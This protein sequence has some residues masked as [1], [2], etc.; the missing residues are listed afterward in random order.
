[1]DVN[2]LI[3]AVSSEANEEYEPD[4]THSHAASR[5]WT[6]GGCASG[7]LAS[8]SLTPARYAQA[9][10]AYT[11]YGRVH[12]WDDV[13]VLLHIEVPPADGGGALSTVFC[14]YVVS[15]RTLIGAWQQA[16]ASTHAAPLEDTFII[17]KVDRPH[18]AAPGAGVRLQRTRVHRRHV[19]EHEREHLHGCASSQCACTTSCCTKFITKHP[20]LLMTLFVGDFMSRAATHTTS[21]RTHFYDQTIFEQTEPKIYFSSRS[22]LECAVHL[23][24]RA[25]GTW[26]GAERTHSRQARHAPAGSGPCWD[27]TVNS[28]RT[29]TQLRASPNVQ[30]AGWGQKRQ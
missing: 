7:S 9:W 3:G 25:S 5:T 15:E 29:C 17:F 22:R 24:Y 27:S 4:D 18:A 19:R 6:L 30:G 16:T 20:S 13:V 21:T 28:F 26:T 8:S 23:S 12:P 1:M 10:H 2:E 14:R 11:L